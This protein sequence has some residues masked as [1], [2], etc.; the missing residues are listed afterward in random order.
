MIITNT[1]L[2]DVQSSVQVFKSFGKVATVVIVDCESGIAV[3]NSW[4]VDTQESFL[5]H[6][7][8]GL[9]LNSLEEVSKLKLD[10]CNIGD[11]CRH[12]IVCCTCHLQ[13]H[14]NSLGVKFKCT[15]K[16][17]LLV[18]LVC[19][20]KTSLDIGVL[21]LDHFDIGEQFVNVS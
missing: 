1:G 14:V 12:F 3:A 4:V 6:D 11:T 19:L 10:A 5:K 7:C 17:I 8:F 18:V 21:V 15:V 9:K 13:E 20:S 16:L 2:Q